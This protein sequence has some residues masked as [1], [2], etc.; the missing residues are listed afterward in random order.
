M[1][2]AIGSRDTPLVGCTA[3]FED[4]MSLLASP[5]LRHRHHQPLAEP[6]TTRTALAV[7]QC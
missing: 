7:T 2:E 3:L 6:I 1:L 4:E 5:N